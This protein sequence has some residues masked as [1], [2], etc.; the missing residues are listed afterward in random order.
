[1]VMTTTLAAGTDY[2]G[3]YSLSLRLVLVAVIGLWRLRAMTTRTVTA[4]S[5]AATVALAAIAVQLIFED[6]AARA[7]HTGSGHAWVYAALQLLVLS[8]AARP[9]ARHRPTAKPS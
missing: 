6:L 3:S 9:G 7:A 2:Y 1:M 5:I 8:I 4:G